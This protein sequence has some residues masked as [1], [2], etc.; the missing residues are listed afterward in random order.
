M[1]REYVGTILL[2]HKNLFEAFIIGNNK[3][4]ED[5][6]PVGSTRIGCDSERRSRYLIRGGTDLIQL[7]CSGLVWLKQMITGYAIIINFGCFKRIG[8]GY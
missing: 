4:I 1:I 8:F 3:F 6:K 7:D 5:L 2:Q